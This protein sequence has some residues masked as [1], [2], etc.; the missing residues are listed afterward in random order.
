VTGF[1]LDVHIPATVVDGVRTQCGCKVY[2][3]SRWR[4]GKFRTA[5]DEV[6]MKAA[7][8][9]GLALVT[10]DV[11]TIP[12]IA[13]RRLARGEPSGLVIFVPSHMRQDVGGL[14]RALVDLYPRLP[15]PDPAYPVVY[16]QPAL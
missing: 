6:I 8:E 1:L 9:S 14:V 2:H 7:R 3:V 11:N 15:Q 4:E 16:L 10:G 12:A 13:Y 5:H